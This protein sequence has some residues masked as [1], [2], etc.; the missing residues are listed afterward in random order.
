MPELRLVIPS[1]PPSNNTYKTYRIAGG[2]KKFVQWYLTARAK[3]WMDEVALAAGGRKIRGTSYAL[4]Y[5]VYMPNAKSTDLDN[6]AKV[7]GDALQHAGVID[8][9]KHITDLHGYRRID[10]VNP[11]TEVIVRTEQTELFGGA[12]CK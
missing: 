8:N 9:D 12:A 11:R 2:A 7:I 4:S 3:A 6:L 10:R 1:I 5:A